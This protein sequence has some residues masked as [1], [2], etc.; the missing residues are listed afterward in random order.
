LSACTVFAENGRRAGRSFNAMPRQASTLSPAQCRACRLFAGQFP[1]PAAKHWKVKA[2]AANRRR[3]QVPAQY[4]QHPA[5]G[6]ATL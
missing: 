2:P 5:M 1:H 6:F 3:S 4:C